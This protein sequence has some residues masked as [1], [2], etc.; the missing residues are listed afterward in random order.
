MKDDFS[1]DQREGCGFRMIEAHC[2]YCEVYFYY[3]YYFYLFIF[4]I[5]FISIS[6]IIAL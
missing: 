2:I 5:I 1:M 6:I 4:I 3:C